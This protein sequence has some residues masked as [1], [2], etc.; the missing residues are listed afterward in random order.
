M[1]CVARGADFAVADRAAARAGPGEEGHDRAGTADF[2]AVIQVVAARIVEVDR[3]LDQALAQQAVV[4]VD[5]GLR[6][7]GDSRNV[8]NT[9]NWLH[10]FR[11]RSLILTM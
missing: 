10:F 11:F 4:E 7:A 6:T 5:I 9:A 3:A 8:V 1:D 2:V